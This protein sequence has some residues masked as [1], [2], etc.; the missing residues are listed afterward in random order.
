MSFSFLLIL[1]YMKFLILFNT[2]AYFLCHCQNKWINVP[3]L[4]ETQSEVDQ[5]DH[6][7]NSTL[8][9]TE[10]LFSDLLHSP[11]NS[12]FWTALSCCCSSELFCFHH[13]MQLL[14]TMYSTWLS[15][16]THDQQLFVN[17]WNL[18]LL[19]IECERP[20]LTPV[21]LY[22]RYHFSYMGTVCSHHLQCM[23]KAYSKETTLLT[24]GK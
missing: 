16:A 20:F 14:E 8:N 2:S 5:E 22:T 9:S 17:R 12:T 1:E 10:L 24:R 11:L 13:H 21:S 23:T 4:A 15:W 18:R 7:G 19:A 3:G 6:I